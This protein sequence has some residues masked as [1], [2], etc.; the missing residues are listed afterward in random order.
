MLRP[1]QSD[2]V[3]RI[4]AALARDDVKAVCAVMP[5][6]AGKTVTFSHITDAH[7]GAVSLMVHRVELV[8]QISLALA[9]V[10]A[11]H[12]IIAP[13]ATISAALA[14]HRRELGRTVYNPHSKHSVCAVD[15]LVARA[16][17]Y[18][19][20]AEQVSLWIIDEAAH[21][22]KENKWGRCAAMFPNAKGIGFTA[23]PK[24]ADGKGL[25][26]HAHGVFDEIIIG[27][28]VAQLIAA[29]FLSPYRLLSKPSDMSLDDLKATAS[30]DFA[31]KTLA[32]RAHDS[33]IVGDVVEHYLKHAPGKQGITF[34][35]DVGTAQD[36][37]EQYRA[38]G[39]PAECVSAKTPEAERARI[40]RKFRA[41][42]LL[43]LT[44]CDLFGEGFDVPGVEV[45]SLARPTCSLALY[46]QQV[47][48]AMRP[49]PGKDSAI[50]IDHVGNWQRHGL[51]DSPRRWNLDARERGVTRDALAGPA[52][53]YCSACF[54]VFLRA[55]LPTCPYCGFTHSATERRRPEQVDGDLSELDPD[56]LAALRES[57]ELEDPDALA[58]RVV[59]AA[60]H[61]AALGAAERQRERIR[62]QQQLRDVIAI[63]AGKGKQAGKSDSELYREFF[64]TFGVDVLTAQTTPRREMDK[65]REE[66]EQTL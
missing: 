19:N 8:C 40:I 51:P 27:P 21:V 47:G 16:D 48:R 3:T 54:L 35:T 62:S 65:L 7:P 64:L 20:W 5:T 53:T 33:H 25:G 34:A 59:H 6:G 61:A 31:Q 15:T 46:L 13:P 2:L 14:E 1:Y 18:K 58:A 36:L 60:G 41:G 38:R 29:G 63:W 9:R 37:A 42:D 55:K 57:V 10:G 66:I 24:R 12:R 30:G 43:Q 22:L 52:V 45:V 56:V 32:M 17:T 28:T 11:E 49:A 50:I 23:T 39:V 26:S 44:N 4:D